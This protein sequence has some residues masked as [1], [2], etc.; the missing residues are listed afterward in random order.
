MK[1]ILVVVVVLIAGVL[2]YAFGSNADRSGTLIES[3]SFAAQPAASAAH[4]PS[5]GEDEPGSKD[6]GGRSIE[7]ESSSNSSKAAEDIAAITLGLRVSSGQSLAAFVRELEAD[8]RAGRTHRSV[9]LARLLASCSTFRINSGR[10]ARGQ[11]DSLHGTVNEICTS[12][13]GYSEG[14]AGELVAAA[15]LAGDARAILEEWY[16]P[17]SSGVGDS[18]VLSWSEGAFGRLERLADSG[19]LDAIFLAAR[20]HQRKT[21]GSGSSDRALHYLDQFLSRAAPSDPR[22][23]TAMAMR[24]SVCMEYDGDSGFQNCRK[25]E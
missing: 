10:A 3:R 14:A 20:Q 1:K 23:S 15:A 8:V 4:V 16:Y 17:P 11:D 12:L 24:K 21:F 22:Y 5:L 6:Q 9:E 13:A 25:D 2:F 19:N 7:P 18:Q